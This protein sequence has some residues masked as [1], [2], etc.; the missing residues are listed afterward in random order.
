MIQEDRLII[1]FDK[2]FGRITLT[3][4]R[5]IGVFLLRIPPVNPEF[6]ARRILVALENVEDPYNKLVVIRKNSIKIIPFR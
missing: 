5:V 4:S 6:V 3:G 2:D 1:T